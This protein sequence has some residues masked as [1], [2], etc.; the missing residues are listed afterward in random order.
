M[1]YKR[2]MVFR[3]KKAKLPQLLY[4]VYRKAIV[5]VTQ[6]TAGNDHTHRLPLH[7]VAYPPH[8]LG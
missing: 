4:L 3:I 6:P 5:A 7:P 1:R 8:R 2:F